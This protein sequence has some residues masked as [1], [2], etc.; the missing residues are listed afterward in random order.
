MNRHEKTDRTN[1]LPGGPMSTQ[2]IRRRRSANAI[3]SDG[4]QAVVERLESRKLLHAIPVDPE[5]PVNLEAGD[6]HDPSIAVDAD[7]DF[8]IAWTSYGQDS[9][10]GKIYA[11]RYNVAG[12]PQGTEFLVN[13]TT[14][15]VQYEPSVA[16]DVDGD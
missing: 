7:G 5:F 15:D 13:T 14:A 4:L 6:R 11:Q 3:K 8:V 1:R 10:Y 16:I 2:N 12:I 9:E